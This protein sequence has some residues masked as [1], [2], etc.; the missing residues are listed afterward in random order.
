MWAHGSFLVNEEWNLGTLS[1]KHFPVLF[2]EYY[3]KAQ[4][5]CENKNITEGIMSAF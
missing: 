2:R 4:E 1:V 5:T 3:I